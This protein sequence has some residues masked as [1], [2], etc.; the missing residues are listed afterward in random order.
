MKT[1]ITVLSLLFLL[2]VGNVNAQV[3]INTDSS[4]P[5]ASS[6][7]DIKS[8]DKGVLV[9]RMDD[10]TMNNIATPATGLMIYNTTANDF[11]YFDGTD[12]EP[13]G[14]TF[15][16]LD[17]IISGDDMYSNVAG[18]VGINTSTPL[19]PLDVN[20]NIRHGNSLSIY[21]QSAGGSKA[22]ATFN[23][24]LNGYGDNVF[25]GAGGTTVLGSGESEVNTKNNIDVTNGHEILYL[26]SDN[27]IKFIN[28]MQDGWDSR[29]EALILDQNKN[30]YAG[31]KNVYLHDDTQGNNSTRFII[32]SDY[33]YGYGVA[34]NGGQGMCIGG[35]ESASKLSDNIDL[36][37]EEVL[38]LT[39]DIKDT[40]QAIKFITSTQD[41]WDDRIEAMTIQGDGKIGIGINYPIGTLHIKASNDAGPNGN[42]DPGADFVI[43]D[44]NAQHLEI[45]GNEMHSMVGKDVAPLY[46]NIDGGKVSFGDVIRLKPSATPT[47]PAEGDIYMDSDTH[48]LRAYDGS[49]WHDLW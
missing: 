37:D 38:Y 5:D 7:L 1:Q 16:D 19:F 22:W 28:K 46:L 9:P 29:V 14:K 40:N 18:N 47:S 15:D 3:G 33:N 34:I 41:L 36:K 30:W 8:V 43:G 24:P 2:I 20:G 32:R 11:Y 21:S 6:M 35:G 39:S 26:T 12:W 42:D 49:S 25:L 17:W 13:I 45:D 23:S 31:F 27:T 48:K 4:N 10:A 44:I